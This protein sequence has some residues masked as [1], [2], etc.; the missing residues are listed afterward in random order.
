MAEI[1]GRGRKGKTKETSFLETGTTSRAVSEALSCL[2]LGC[3]KET[4]VV[5]VVHPFGQVF[6]PHLPENI[7]E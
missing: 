3:A 4:E 1:L 6:I 2:R 5:A 7:V